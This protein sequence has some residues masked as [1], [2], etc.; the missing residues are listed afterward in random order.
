MYIQFYFYDGTG[1]EGPILR[2]ASSEIQCPATDRENFHAFLHAAFQNIAEQ[3]REQLF[4]F[5]S[6]QEGCIA[7]EVLGGADVSSGRLLAILYNPISHQVDAR[8]KTLPR[9]QPPD[10]N[11]GEDNSRML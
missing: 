2:E 1:S 10:A 4:V 11:F 9:R 5:H 6:G 7:A 8:V 3:R